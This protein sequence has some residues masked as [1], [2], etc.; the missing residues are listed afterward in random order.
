M[1]FEPLLRRL[2]LGWRSSCGATLMVDC[3]CLEAACK[4]PYIPML[5]KVILRT[6]VPT[7]SLPPGA[8]WSK[9]CVLSHV[10]LPFEYVEGPVEA[11]LWAKGQSTES[12][13]VGQSVKIRMSGPQDRL[14]TSRST[15]PYRP[16][17]FQVLTHGGFVCST[18]P[19]PRLSQD[20]T[21][22]II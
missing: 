16:Y 20:I 4:T 3:W 21:E 22:L 8:P 5:C 14:S 1:S 15:H 10:T 12:D 18:S 6:K 2:S 9:K 11:F 17:R 19:R 13:R 7:E